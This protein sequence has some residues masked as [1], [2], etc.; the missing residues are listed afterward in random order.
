MARKAMEV[1]QVVVDELAEREG[2]ILAEKA[3][4]FDGNAFR[5]YLEEVDRIMEEGSL[6]FN[7]ARRHGKRGRSRLDSIH[8]HLRTF[9]I[10]GDS[11]Q[12][13]IKE[14]G[15]LILNRV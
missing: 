5:S 14:L 15:G 7:E 13:S 8:E 10:S 12:E 4:Y 9:F 6:E 2:N 1:Y 11:P 3:E